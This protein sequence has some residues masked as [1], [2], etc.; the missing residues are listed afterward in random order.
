MSYVIIM[1]HKVAIVEEIISQVSEGE[2]PKTALGVLGSGA[3]LFPG[4]SPFLGSDL[5]LLTWKMGTVMAPLPAIVM[6]W[7]HGL[8]QVQVLEQGQ[9]YSKWMLPRTFSQNPCPLQCARST[10]GTREG[11]GE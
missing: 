11:L 7:S 5:S 10:M 6:L 2:A 1:H 9:G 8:G 3:A 4:V